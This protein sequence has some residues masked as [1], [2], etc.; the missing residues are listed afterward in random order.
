MNDNILDAYLSGNYDEANRLIG[1][2]GMSAQDVVNKYNLNQ[3]QATDVAKNLGYTGNLSGLSYLEQPKAQMSNAVTSAPPANAYDLDYFGN[4]KNTQVPVYENTYS[5]T[6]TANPWASAPTQKAPDPVDKDIFDYF[7]R[8]QNLVKNKDYSTIASDMYT[9]G[10]TPEMVARSTGTNVAD[11]ANQYNQTYGA[12]DRATQEDLVNQKYKK[13]LGLTD[14][15]LSQRDFGA[16]M[17]TRENRLSS[18]PLSNAYERYQ[19]ELA[20]TGR[21]DAPAGTQFRAKAVYMPDS[22]GNRGSIKLIDTATGQELTNFGA[23]DIG[24]T[25]NAF[26]LLDKFGVDPASY[27]SAASQMY[28][29][30]GKP[31][32]MQDDYAY[33]TGYKPRDV[34]GA[35]SAFL[36]K[37]L[38]NVT[39]ADLKPKYEK[40]DNARQTADSKTN[41]FWMRPMQELLM[42][43]GMGASEATNYLHQLAPVS[44]LV[45]WAEISRSKDPV[46][47]I[48]G[49]LNYFQ[50]KG[51][52]NRRF[53]AGGLT[54]NSYF[55][56]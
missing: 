18:S 11:V 5:G 22:I 50:S 27:R 49:T 29:S 52:T 19:E 1:A 40:D 28:E 44:G 46:K 54:S 6:P 12:F 21:R 23:N 13:L 4:P 31:T 45:N 53:A 41:V 43:K 7:T 35:T 26:E 38:A 34:S 3:Q 55:S 17:D 47:A 16:A 39:Y 33:L 2:A 56:T 32:Y 42:S 8:N 24:N 36:T 25:R 20:A 48:I 9:S 15:Q 37:P 51:L 10:W 30:L 14:E